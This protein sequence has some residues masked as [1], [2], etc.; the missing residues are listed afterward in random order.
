MCKMFRIALFLF[1]LNLC[2]C[3]SDK[4]LSNE[5]KEYENIHDVKHNLRYDFSSKNDSSQHKRNHL[6]IK[7]D[8]KNNYAESN[9]ETV[10]TVDIAADSNRKGIKN[11]ADDGS[12]TSTRAS[13]MHKHLNVLGQKGA[14]PQSEPQLSKNNLKFEQ[15]IWGNDSDT[16]ETR[17]DELKAKEG[18]GEDNPEKRGQEETDQA[19]R[20]KS[21]EQAESDNDRRDGVVKDGT[22]D[23]ARDV[24]QKEQKEQN[25]EPGDVQIES[26]LSEPGQT[27]DGKQVQESV[28]RDA[29]LTTQE[30]GHTTE[31]LE[32]KTVQ[33]S[34]D[35]DSK[36]TS[37]PGTDA[38]KQ[39]AQREGETP[40]PPLVNNNDQGTSSP[41]G[42]AT[43]EIVS[44][45]ESEETSVLLGSPPRLE[46]ESD[47]SVVLTTK[48]EEEASSPTSAEQPR[49]PEVDSHS[50]PAGL[51]NADTQKEP[52]SG[53]VERPTAETK[54]EKAVETEEK[55]AEQT[56][57]EPV[58]Q[59]EDT[60]EAGPVD[61]KE[62]DEDIGR[63]TLEEAKRDGDPPV[64]PVH[65]PEQPMVQIQKGK[66]EEQNILEPVS[67]P[68]GE[69]HNT[70]DVDEA[71][72]DEI[73]EEQKQEEDEEEDISEEEIQKL[74]QD[75]G[76]QE[77]ER[78][79][80][81]DDEEE[82]EDEIEKNEEENETNNPDKADESGHI[83]KVKEGETKN[84]APNDNN[85][86]KSLT[87]EYKND[88]DVKKVA[89]EVVKKV[90]D[91]VSSDTTVLNTLK[92]L[93]N[94]MHQY[95]QYV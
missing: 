27:L 61:G 25:H 59:T 85:I 10:E 71:I 76:M 17:V 51:E 12:T 26:R 60:L 31:S 67:L 28:A 21:K 11:F 37:L 44:G 35:L 53:S 22:K 89:E 46:G 24:E 4:K 47:S 55:Q 42:H 38:E 94:Y 63:K 15:H 64:P 66:K 74:I 6:R 32:G 13:A 29:S 41:P 62:G 91:S 93:E 50:K 9:T 78:L 5:I 58:A 69:T 83:N 57:E 88:N 40:S 80:E 14:N 7:D 16:E 77:G 43:K 30:A 65:K 92:G 81:G 90:I 87:E 49:P 1:F 2:I 95:F 75:D 20:G 68:N 84:E 70:V 39:D 18:G 19:E 45:R 8:I 48:P 36:Q 73:E 52:V 23:I 72:T 56:E 86:H 3:E 34:E 54:D 82:E 33:R 79:K